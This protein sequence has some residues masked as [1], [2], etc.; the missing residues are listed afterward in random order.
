MQIIV[1]ALSPYTLDSLKEEH[2]TLKSQLSK[3]LLHLLSI[4][5]KQ[6]LRRFNS[7]V[8]NQSFLNWALRE[9]VLLQTKLGNSG[10]NAITL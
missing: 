5:Y 8:S 3:A 1:L 2:L 6:L 10:N 9:D 7:N 4:K